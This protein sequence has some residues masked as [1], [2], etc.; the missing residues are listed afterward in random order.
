MYHCLRVGVGVLVLE[1]VVGVEERLAEAVPVAELLGVP[2]RE[3]E[4]LELSVREAERLDVSV[5]V[6]ELVSELVCVKLGVL[7]LDG[8]GVVSAMV[9]SRMEFRPRASRPAWTARA[10]GVAC[11]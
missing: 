7:V 2:E 6:A 3:A 5:C 10:Q 1:R 8:V 4:L 9:P 11:A